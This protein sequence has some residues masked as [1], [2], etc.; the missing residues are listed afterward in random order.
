[1]RNDDNSKISE[2]IFVAKE[3]PCFSLDNLA[4]LETDKTYLKILLGRYVKA[5]KLF[6]LKKGLYVAKEYIDNVQKRGH[7]SH[8]L[9][10]LNG[11]LCEPSYLSLEYVLYRHNFLTDV[12]Y[13]FTSITKS[14]TAV[15]TNEL[16]TFFYY[17]I[18]DSLFCGYKMV[19]EGEFS[20]LR[21]SLSKA[22]FDFLYLRK[23]ILPVKEAVKEL[24]LNVDLLKKIDLK[25]LKGYVEMEGS[26]KMKEIV[27][28]LL[29]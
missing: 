16:G 18:K 23:N 26:K 24:R 22:L 17:K 4:T 13:N 7:F 3:L 20:F 12:P 5:G 29:S 19:K 15:F 27:M 6:R 8:Y 21:A 2:I 9:N 28:H 11:V 14:K 1:M 25:E 10:F